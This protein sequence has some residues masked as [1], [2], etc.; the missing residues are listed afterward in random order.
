MSESEEVKAI[1]WVRENCT[2]QACKVSTQLNE[3]ERNDK[4]FPVIKVKSKPIQE[5]IYVGRPLFPVRGGGA[6]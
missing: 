5:R 2:C 3:D 4:H 1:D 6:T